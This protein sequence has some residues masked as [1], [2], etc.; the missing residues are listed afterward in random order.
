MQNRHYDRFLQ[1]VRETD[2]DVILAVEVDD[3]WLTQLQPLEH[4]YA[5]VVRQPQNNMY[6]MILL[7]RLK[8]IEPQV[9]FLVQS[10][11][12]SIHTEIELR[13]GVRIAFYGLHPPPPEP[14]RNQD[15]TL[16]NAELVLVGRDS[17][18]YQR[19]TV[20][21]GDLNDVAWSHTTKLF[22]RLSG[23]LEP[24]VGRGLYKTF[25]A[26]NPLF[27]IPLDHVFHSP[28]F[29]LVAL[30]RL[31]HI[32]SDHFPICIDLHYEPRA[33]SEQPPMER[34]PELEKEAQEQVDMAM[35]SRSSQGETAE[36]RGAPAPGEGM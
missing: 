29:T 1:V 7:S 2:P 6:G 21:A 19:P 11:I 18:Q 5:Y 4:T 15:A 31:K 9:R 32:G 34:G 33:S 20:V 14:I 35:P 36:P 10:A 28:C 25:K 12:P 3:R 16:R 24:R 23:L 22:L 30:R 26:N 8:L 27:R 17:R 13:N